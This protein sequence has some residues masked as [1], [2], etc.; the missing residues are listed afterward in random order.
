MHVLRFCWHHHVE[1]LKAC[2][3]LNHEAWFGELVVYCEREGQG[4]CC[5][6]VIMFAEYVSLF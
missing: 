2:N 6:W 1:N 4:R 5:S 3:M